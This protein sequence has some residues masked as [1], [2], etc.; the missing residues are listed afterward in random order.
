MELVQPKVFIIGESRIIEDELQLYLDHIGVSEWDSDAVS[1][2]E[3]II[4]VMGRLCYRSFKPGLNPNV[5]KIRERNDDYLKNIVKTKHGS[6]LEHSFINFI[7]ADVSRVF[8]HELVRHRV[9]VAISQ[10]SLR[11]VRLDKLRFWLPSCIKNHPQR[12]A[13][14]KI[15]TDTIEYLEKRQLELAQILELDNE[16]DFHMKKKY[17]SAMRRLAPDGLA[18]TIGWSANPRA[19]RHIIE[20]RSAV[21]AEEEIRL[22]AGLIAEKVMKKYPN[23]FGDYTEEMEDGLPRYKTEY[24]KI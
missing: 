22:V 23:T 24:D 16:K 21:E 2:V 19:I 18:T 10:E 5:T 7:L 6:V 14:L 1:D 11:F 20:M 8:T 13:L 15:F 4:E 3:K 12:E 9:G 17:T